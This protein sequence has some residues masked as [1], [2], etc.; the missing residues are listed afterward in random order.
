MPLPILSNP[1]ESDLI[2][3]F[4]RM[5]LHFTQHLGESTDL[6]VG[7]AIS[8]PALANV[9]DANVLMDA[10]LPDGV[11]PEQAIAE[12]NQHYLAAGTVC[13]TWVMN[14]SAPKERTEP[15]A[16]HLLDRGAGI[17]ANDILYLRGRPAVTIREQPGLT[18]IPARASYKHAR[19]LAEIS[20]QE[21][22]DEPQLVD[23]QLA[24]LDDPHWDC[25]LALRDGQP[26]ATAGVLAVGEAGLIEDVYV[27]PG[28]RRLGV[29]MT[30]M[31]RVLEICARSLFKHVMLSCMPSNTPAQTMYGRLGFQKV[32]TFTAYCPGGLPVKKA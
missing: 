16:A 8:N 7:T 13:R 28:M 32:G 26:V 20:Q 14:P 24:H 2:R 10:S 15:L 25:L 23:A 22:W 4:H 29:G 11:S 18:I 21:S 1:V 6:D 5:T 9:Y 3:L 19:Q 12:V 31:S 30:M 27:A 17:V